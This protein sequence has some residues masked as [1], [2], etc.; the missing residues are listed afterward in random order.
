MLY[1]LE[2]LTN[3][4]GKQGAMV[5]ILPGHSVMQGRIQGLGY[6]SAPFP[7]GIL[8]SHTFHHS[9]IDTSLK[10]YATGDRLFNTSPGEK[11]YRLGQLTASYLHCY[12]P[13]NPT[14]TAQLFLP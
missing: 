8:R 10:E 5:G 4:T 13:S 3:K 2:S 9:V 6:Q 1:L 7:G 12:F 11:I 14:A